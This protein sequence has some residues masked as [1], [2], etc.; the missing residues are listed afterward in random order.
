MS[1]TKKKK[2]KTRKTTPAG[3]GYPDVAQALKALKMLL[4]NASYPTKLERDVDV[5]GMSEAALATIRYALTEYTDLL[6]DAS[7]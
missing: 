2:Q 1:K 4:H 3:Q 6:D 5:V 7:P